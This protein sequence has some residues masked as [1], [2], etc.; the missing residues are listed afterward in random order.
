MSATGGNNEVHFLLERHDKNSA[1]LSDVPG[2]TD[3]IEAGC[4][5]VFEATIWFSA[6]ELGGSKWAIGGTAQADRVIWCG[7]ILNENNE[8]ILPIYPKHDLGETHEDGRSRIGFLKI[9]G[10]VKAA[11]TGTLAVQFAQQQ[12]SEISSVLPGSHFI[13]KPAS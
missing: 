8:E 10:F 4:S 7:Q 12:P 9:W 6:S 13:V 3:Q 2:L 11:T 1:A 5:Y